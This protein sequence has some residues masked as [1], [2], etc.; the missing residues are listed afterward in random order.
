M[1]GKCL[2]Y[3]NACLTL[4]PYKQ[5]EM[6]GRELVYW[7]KLNEFSMDIHWLQDVTTTLLSLGTHLN[8][9][10]KSLEWIQFE[11]FVR[12]HCTLK[13]VLGCKYRSAMG[14]QTLREVYSDTTG[15]L[16]MKRE[17]TF[18][19][20]LWPEG[21]SENQARSTQPH[22]ASHSSSGFLRTMTVDISAPPAAN[23]S[24]LISAPACH[25]WLVELFIQTC[26]NN[27]PWACQ[28]HCFICAEIKIKQ[29]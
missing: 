28:C 23:S 19:Q 22:L 26:W 4:H 12:V 18:G 5:K 21:Y 8:L 15:L 7:W 6:V 16:E 3:E 20:R 29:V 27:N 13:C 11:N 14:E 9:L 2:D 17:N 24:R 10:S 1:E 25:T